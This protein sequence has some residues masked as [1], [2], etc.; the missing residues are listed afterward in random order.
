MRTHEAGTLHADV[1]QPS[2]SVLQPA[3]LTALAP[4]VWPRSA[5][6]R[7]DGVLSIGGVDVRD[8]A[9]EFGTPA[10]ICDEADF[11]S[12]CRD[13]ATAFADFDVHYAAKAFCSTTV[14]RWV[15][16]EGLGLDV[17]TGGELA[18]A[19]R[20]G[21]PVDRIAMHGNNKSVSELERAVDAGIGRI[22]VDSFAEIARLAWL[23]E[24]RGIRQPVL[25]RA[26]VGVEAH[27]HEFIATAHED[28]KFGFS[29]ASG[30][31]FEAVQRVLGHPGLELAGLHTPIGTPIFDTSG[32]EI[33]ARRTVGLLARI[34]DELDA[35]PGF[36]DLGGG[37]G[38]AYTAGDDP[39]DAAAVGAGL[40]DIVQ[41]ECAAAGLTPPRL[42]VEPGR[43]IAGPGTVTLYEVG[44]VKDV[45]GI[46]TYVSVDGGMSDNIRTALYD[47]AYT[48]TLASR[49]STAAPML[50]RVVGKHCESGDIVVRDCWLPADLSPG[51]LLAVAATGAYCRSLANNYN[52]QPRP[53]VVSVRDGTARVLVRRETEDDLLRLDVA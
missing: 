30:A 7:P 27:T 14:L 8:L 19:L 16:E 25:V 17:C 42:A 12:R 43:A 45:D 4:A 23:A 37:F 9:E 2:S 53:P 49:A 6:R 32:V 33:S 35:E 46:R 22:V 40:R 5:A 31:A 10:Y 34:R 24:Q 51:D 29:L 48:V 41:R 28:Q 52:H 20:A 15:A 36:L 38:I 3:D 13:F 11:R 21:F 50:A 39:L 18:V 26:T 47:A 44:T 1:T